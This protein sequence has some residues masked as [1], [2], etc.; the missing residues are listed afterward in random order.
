MRHM[1]ECNG[2]IY[3]T[4][5]LAILCTMA[6]MLLWGF[7]YIWKCHHIFIFHTATV[8][9]EVARSSETSAVQPIS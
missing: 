6:V 5:D 9:M 3:T 7:C 8:Q 4:A 1:S 2:S